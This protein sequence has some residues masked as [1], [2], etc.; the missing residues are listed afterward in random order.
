MRAPCSSRRRRRRVRWSRLHAMACESWSH[1]TAYWTALST[2]LCTRFSAVRRLLLICLCAICGCS[3]HPDC[4]TEFRRYWHVESKSPVLL[5]SSP[6]HQA[7]QVC[8][9][10]AAAAVRASKAFD[11]LYETCMAG[12]GVE[13]PE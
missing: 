11:A 1:Q 13:T 5:T 4:A 7:L 8:C 2:A 9:T 6:E 12:T 3:S 10:K